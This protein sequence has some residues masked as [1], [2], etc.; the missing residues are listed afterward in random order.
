MDDRDYP[1]PPAA[2]P[3]ADPALRLRAELASLREE[4]DLAA[5]VVRERA[6]LLE[7]EAVDRL[8]SAP[9]GGRRW[10][11]RYADLIDAVVRRLWGLARERTGHESGGGSSGHGGGP[12][13][14]VLAAGGYGMRWLAP[15]SDLDLTIVAARNDDPPVL[16]ELFRL[17][18]GVLTSGARL[19]VGYGYRTLADVGGDLG[20]EETEADGGNG[21]SSGGIIT[22]DHQTQTALL[23]ARLVAGD[24]AL[25]ARF[26]RQFHQ[27]LQVADFLF[28]KEAERRRRREK[29]GAT[30]RVSEPNIK[31]GPGGL[32][33]LQ[34]AGW[35]ARVR[36]GRRGGGDNALWHDL[37][38]RRILT[39]DEQNDLEAARALLLTV[40]C[41]VHRVSGERRD[42][43]SRARQENIAALLEPDAR[44]PS[45]ALERFMRRWYGASDHLQQISEKVV[46][47]CLDAPLPL[48]G[49]GLSAVR[50]AVVL[51]DPSR[52]VEDLFW[53]VRALA[54]CQTYGLS[55][56]MATEEAMQRWAE[57]TRAATESA[58]S[59]AS[60]AGS[61]PSPL[62]ATIRAALGPALVELLG[63]AGDITGTVRRMERTGLLELTLPELAACMGLVPYDPAH[64][65]T[66]GEHT[67]RVLE[68]LTRLRPP[69]S[70]AVGYPASQH[71]AEAADPEVTACREILVGLESPATLYVAALLHDIGKQW[72]T[73]RDGATRAPHEETGA[74]RVPEIC[75]R[76][77]CPPAMAERVTLLV[78]HHLL[79]AETSRL[80]DLNLPET[81]RD[82]VDAL[83]GD[84]ENLR[85]L[86]LLTRA[87]TA[88]VAPGI[89]TPMKARQLAEL[90]HRA[91][92]HLTA[93]EEAAATV[94]APPFS[95]PAGGT[96]AAAAGGGGGVSA[97]PED[98][99]RLKAARDRVR[100]QL[101][102][103]A[104][105]AGSATGTGDAAESVRVHIEA[106]PAAY[107]LNTPLPV[108][109]RHLSMVA[110]LVETGR[111][112]VDI[113]TPAPDAT[114]SELTVVT[115]DDPEPGLLSKIAGALVAFDIN[116]HSVQA[117]TRPVD[118]PQAEGGGDL[119]PAHA[120]VI[121]V[122]TLTID[123]RDRPLAPLKRADVEE[124]LMAALAGE[125]SV[126]DLLRRRR[127]GGGGDAGRDGTGRTM[128]APVRLLAADDRVGGGEGAGST[129]LDLEAP[130][131]P[132]LVYHLTHLFSE[133]GW[134]IH[135]ARLSAWAGMVRLAVYVTDRR[136][137]P[138]PADEA[139][140]RLDA[141]FSPSADEPPATG[142]E[143]HTA[144]EES[145]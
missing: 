4:K 87:D 98:P 83:G 56:A 14:A 119:P 140:D 15:H 143:V 79:M 123:Y 9:E 110:R 16:R 144:A 23:E 111:P 78:R 92:S 137:D 91:E 112:V 135:A 115:Y 93:R 51:G 106:M 65:C 47:R 48:D 66:V 70:A 34:T 121:V 113:R 99:D 94:A 61:G 68:N 31:E 108:Q 107:L 11:H 40:R 39:R 86:Y 22:L 33:D 90:Y 24:P 139:W 13:I 19:S 81:I 29:Y 57:E 42:L 131:E 134:N 59:S 132:G 54:Y 35:M 44:S 75:A 84:R 46:A 43:L 77:G 71:A 1:P 125:T 36:F 50:R 72:P 41:L 73:L 127:G 28:R 2:A 130:D 101:A 58:A 49:H 60:A 17:I 97:V 7:G 80:R 122:D 38:R 45:D 136:G 37:V 6:A 142:S 82:F 64:A 74:E 129:L 25:F 12:G 89:W 118:P 52:A 63:R 117:F 145:R 27:H 62:A 21:G 102:R 30:P 124:A 3:E 126:T 96:R 105:R 76:L 109:A 138:V 103:E 55:L 8:L 18:M 10:M 85:M 104:E 32:R 88:A 5:F 69:E 53:P 26:D 67:L 128:R 141:A 100:R 116:V 95:P 133:L 120:P 20:P 114:Y